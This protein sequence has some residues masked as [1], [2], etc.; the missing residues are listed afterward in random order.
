VG[1]GVWESFGGY[2]TQAAVD[3]SRRVADELRAYSRAARRRA[4]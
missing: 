1:S 3:V 4:P 2:E